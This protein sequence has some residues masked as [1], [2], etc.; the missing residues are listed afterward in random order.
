V[1]TLK[2]LYARVTSLAFSP[3]GKSLA[4]CSGRASLWDLATGKRLRDYEALADGK[5][6]EVLTALFAPNGR[7]LLTGDAAG[8]IRVWDLSSVTELRHLEGHKGPVLG[9]ALSPGGAALASA[10]GDGTLRLWRAATGKAFRTLGEPGPALTCVRFSPDGKSLAAADHEGRLR[11]WDVASGKEVRPPGPRV[12]Y[13]AVG[14]TAEGRGVVALTPRAITH[15]RLPGGRL[16]RQV[17]LPGGEVVASLLSPDAR[18]LALLGEDKHL[19]LLDPATGKE[20][21]Q[22]KEPFERGV[23]LAFSPEGRRLALV[24]PDEPQAV[25][26]WDTATGRELPPLRDT[27]AR[28]PQPMLAFAPDGRTILTGHPEAWTVRRWELATGKERRPFVIPPVARTGDERVRGHFVIVRGGAVIETRSDSP[29]ALALSPDGQL[30]AV[31]QAESVCLCSLATGQVVRRCGHDLKVNAL[32]LSPSGKLLATASDDRTVRLWDV[33]TGRQLARLR[34]HRGAVHLLAFSPDGGTLVSA[35]QDATA[36]VWDVASALRLPPERP[37]ALPAR[38]LEA[39]W[40]DL[41]GDDPALAESARQHM[42]RSP[43][44]TVSFLKD[45]LRPVPPVPAGRLARLIADLGSTHF[46]ARDRAT[47]QLEELAEQAGP[48]LRQADSRPDL[49]AETRTRLRR[50]LDKLDQPNPSG[51][52]ARPLRAVE[53]LEHIA[54]PEARK[55]LDALSRGDPASPLTRDAKASLRRLALRK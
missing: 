35:S 33:H 22:F 30:L 14:L 25:R 15:H 50:L 47:R 48:A 26:L 21:H 40:A 42:E 11:L 52:A 23:L 46:E 36:L 8:F 10:S 2:G 55:L 19:R 45:R 12:P 29:A 17:R 28:V 32:A 34:G 16:T 1:R 18:L 4:S 41:A 51:E 20:L 54:T 43:A 5:P 38:A 49:S 44:R 9:L 7:S 37:P 6:A 24:A 53:A 31:A 13:S 39:L 27:S 3:D